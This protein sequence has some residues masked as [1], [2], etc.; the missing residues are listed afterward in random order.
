MDLPHHPYSSEGRR[1]RYGELA[2]LPLP[3]LAFDD[4]DKSLPLAT[5]AAAAANRLMTT[6]SVIRRPSSA[7]IA[8]AEAD[9]IMMDYSSSR[10]PSSHHQRFYNTM[11]NTSTA[12]G[13]PTS[14]SAAPLFT[15]TISDRPFEVTPIRRNA[16]F[17]RM[18]AR[19]DIAHVT[20]PTSSSSPI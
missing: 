3:R 6:P 8:D 20:A 13:R 18:D 17:G 9:T 4:I 12:S 10:S 19:L 1:R 11:N 5:S 15:S 14:P 2:P 7:Y 16:N